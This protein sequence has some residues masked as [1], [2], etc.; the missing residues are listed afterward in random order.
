[1]NPFGVIFGLS[2][3][4]KVIGK[5]WKF[6]TNESNIEIDADFVELSQRDFYNENE[7]SIESGDGEK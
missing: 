4:R 7:K 5:V 1:M 6:L 2:Y 3:Q